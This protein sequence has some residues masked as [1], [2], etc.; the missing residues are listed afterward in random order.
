[1]QQQE[2]AGARTRFGEGSRRQ[3]LEVTRQ[4]AGHACVDVAVVERTSHK[5]DHMQRQEGPR[6]NDDRP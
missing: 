6:Y 4:G 5:G 3:S 2:V 1:M